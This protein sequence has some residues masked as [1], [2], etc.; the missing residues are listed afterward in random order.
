VST[1]GI[2]GGLR[3]GAPTKPTRDTTVDVLQ[4]TRPSVSR[5]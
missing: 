5:E 2:S 1:V 3:V 4:I